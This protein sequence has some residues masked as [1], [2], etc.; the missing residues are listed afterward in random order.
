V[1]VLRAAVCESPRLL[2]DSRSARARPDA[3]VEQPH[4]PLFTTEG[5]ERADEILTEVYEAAG[6]PDHY[7]CSFYD[8]THKFDR[9]MQAEAFEWFDRVLR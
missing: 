2:R 4:D 5:Q 8:G 1:D 9:E 6:A 7:R 3:G